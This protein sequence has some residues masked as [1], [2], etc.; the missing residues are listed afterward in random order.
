MTSSATRIAVAATC[1]F[2]VCLPRVDAC[3]FCLSMP[4]TTVADRLIGGEA[5]VFS[6][7]DPDKPFSFQAIEVLK[8]TLDST[9]IDLFLDSP[10]R[11]RLEFNK[12]LVIVLVRDRT[13]RSWRTVGIAADTYQQ[14]VRRILAFAQE[15]TGPTG[16]EKRIEFFLTFFG[17]ENRALSELAYLEL[18]RAPYRT[19]KRFG[20]HVSRKDLQPFLQHRDYIQWRSLAILLL[21]QSADAQDRAS[22]D[23]N[24][25]DCCEF[26]L[27]TNLAAW[28][29]AYIELNGAIAIERI[30]REY[31][32]NPGRSDKEVRAIVT[33]LSLHSQDGHTQLREQIVRSYE[34]AMRNYPE[35]AKLIAKDLAK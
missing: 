25:A 20:R 16:A 5:V 4:Q 15:W 26:S 29:T 31:F 11:R 34:I 10:N 35:V 32:A 28:A 19:I 1:L 22:I 7:E 33:A 21:S 3:I 9:T 27:T 24:F 17:H 23:K 13:D 12:N 14:V 8:G 18:G 6:R 30:E 2:C